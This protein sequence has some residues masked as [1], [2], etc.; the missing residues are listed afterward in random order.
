QLRRRVRVDRLVAAVRDKALDHRVRVVPGSA[1]RSARGRARYGRSIVNLTGDPGFSSLHACLRIACVDNGK[2]LTWRSAVVPVPARGRV[3]VG[4]AV[5]GPADPRERAIGA[6]VQW[7]RSG[8]RPLWLVEGGAGV[9]KTRLAGEVADRMV[10][11]RWP[12]GWARPGLGAYAV[13]AAVRNGR[14][15]LVLVDDA[16]TR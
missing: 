16:E 14:P 4:Q 11:E 10:A 12:A 9:G 13:S 7:C 15:A 8:D 6:M 1:G 3:R 2:Q 5:P